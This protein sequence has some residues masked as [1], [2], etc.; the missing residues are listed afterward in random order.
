MTDIGKKPPQPDVSRSPAAKDASRS[1]GDLISRW[2]ARKHAVAQSEAAAARAQTEAGREEAERAETQARQTANREQAEAIDI[3]TADYKTD[4]T[5]FLKDGVPPALRRQA[6][7]ALWRTNPIL[8][9]VD[10]LNDYDEDF[11]AVGSAFEIIKSTWQV[12][13]G[14]A[15]KADEVA[16]EMDARDEEVRKAMADE[17]D[18]DDRIADGDNGDAG[19]HDAGDHDGGNIVADDAD[20][21]PQAE[22]ADTTPPPVLPRSRR[23]TLRRRLLQDRN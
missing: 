8:A 11:R 1:E 22:V 3:D 23:A 7:K 5:P 6:L 9:N 14:Y 19:D 12:G 20:E 17:G 4:F 13:R 16:G 18:T 2:A 10:G 15:D 21:V